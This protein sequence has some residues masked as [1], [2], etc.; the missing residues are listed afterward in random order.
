[1]ASITIATLFVVAACTVAPDASPAPSSSPDPTQLALASPSPRP[2]A[3]PIPRPTASPSPTP[4]A[5]PS[6]SPSSGEPTPLA[7][8]PGT[9]H[10][11]PD[12]EAY[13]PTLLSKTPLIRT[14]MKGSVFT[15]GS[16]MCIL[17]CGDEP[18][19]YAKELGIPVDRV[20][21]AFAVSDRLALGMIGYRARGAKPD[22][23][24]P[25]RIAIGG[26]TGN[27]GP[28]WKVTV[29]ARPVTFL[30][31]RL[32]SGEYLYARDE[33]LFI[34]LGAPPDKAGKVP[35]YITEAIGSIP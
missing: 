13:L 6:P 27:G 1:M 32:D 2:T 16:D 28:S 10:V 26:Q 3:T 4:T 25:A 22:R 19:K 14:S 9:P 30:M 5:T 34:V 18:T 7:E 11:D 24:I 20:T 15:G 17:L 12:L 31:S 21:V 8:A 23:L 33:L 29:G 35:S